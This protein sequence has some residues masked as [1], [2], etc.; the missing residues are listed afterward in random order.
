M[1]WDITVNQTD[2]YVVGLVGKAGSQADCSLPLQILRQSMTESLHPPPAF[3]GCNVH[4]TQH[5]E[6]V[7]VYLI[8]RLQKRESVLTR[9][10]AASV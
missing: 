10:A 5:K 2:A 6:C 4:Y 9:E 7:T 8:V 3:R 1:E